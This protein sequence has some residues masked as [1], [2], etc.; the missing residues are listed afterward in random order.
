MYTFSS[1]LH[2]Y[3]VWLKRHRIR[4]RERFTS[5][6]DVEIEIEFERIHRHD[7][8][9]LRNGNLLFLQTEHLAGNDTHAVVFAF[10]GWPEL[11]FGDG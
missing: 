5:P 8:R 1:L 7:W 2:R 10:T 6:I 3:Q 4:A 9:R 11:A